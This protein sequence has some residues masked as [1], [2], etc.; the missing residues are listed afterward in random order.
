MYYGQ[1]N[2][3]KQMQGIPPTKYTIAQ[4]GCFLTAF[5]NLLSDNGRNISPLDLNAFFRDKRIYIDADDGIRD[6]LYWGAVSKFEP[7]L[8]VS[9]LANGGQPPHTN[10]IIKMNARNTFG[11]HF[12]KVHRISGNS[13]QIIDSW[14]GKI[15]QSSA[16]GKILGWASYKKIGAKPTPEKPHTYKVKKS[17]S[18]GLIAAM[19]RIGYGKRW[20]DVARLN[21]LRPPYIIH[22]GQVLKLPS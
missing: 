18:D 5:C 9:D 14:D 11:T 21:N 16:Y 1:I 15:K 19:S 8:I 10:S 13:V 7:K 3:K 6:D 20:Q 12:C 2:Y 4:I 22:P 17:D